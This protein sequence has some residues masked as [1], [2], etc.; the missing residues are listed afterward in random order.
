MRPALALLALGLLL[1]TGCS[2]SIPIRSLQPAP[3]S[4]GPARHLELLQAE[5]RRSAQETV[6]HE[7]TAQARSQGYF[8]TRDLTQKGFEVRTFGRKVRVRDADGRPQRLAPERV[9][10]RVDVLEWNAFRDLRE[11]K[12]K[13]DDGETTTTTQ[14][15]LIGSV[16]LGITLFDD[17]FQAI[18]AEREYLGRA[19]EKAGRASRDVLLEKAA[20]RAVA[21]FLADVTPRRV[22]TSVRL[23]DADD[24][25]AH[26]LETAKAGNT[27]QAALDA[28][29]YREAH[30]R[31]AAA[32][33]NLAVLVDAMGD[34][35][36]ALALYDEALRLGS[37]DFYVQARASCARRLAASQE[38]ASDALPASPARSRGEDVP[39]KLRPY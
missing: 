28:R 2:T 25:Q 24:G 32:A 8:T 14:A 3:I 10:V 1:P 18:L 17:S 22:Q 16:V 9:G 30:P 4:L 19:S 11:V 20:S 38:L 29:R 37:K 35:Q 34:H 26:I 15:R 33:Y 23:D 27:A 12:S 6:V 5:G 31:N 36:E 21:S 39:A 13:D 7:L